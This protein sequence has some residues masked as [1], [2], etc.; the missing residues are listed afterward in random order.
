VP[1]ILDDARDAAV[2]TRPEIQSSEKQVRHILV[3]LV[4]ACSAPGPKAAALAASFIRLP[5]LPR[6]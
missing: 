2:G 3:D 6:C 4:I 1:R 5:A